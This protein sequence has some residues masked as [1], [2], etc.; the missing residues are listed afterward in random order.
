MNTNG[1]EIERKFLIVYPDAEVLAGCEMSEITQTYLSGSAAGFSERV[2]KRGANGAFTYT[3]T[4]KTHINDMRRIEIEEEISRE[5]YA[6]LLE[7]ADPERRV[8]HKKRFCLEH[9]G[10]I[11]EID[12]YPFWADRAVMEVELGDETESFDFPPEILII[13]EVTGDKRY[14]NASIARNIPTDELKG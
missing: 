9:G 2:R 7:R 12:L 3:H 6:K 10:K 11:F 4:R 13:K 8:I 1:M 14:T 5:E